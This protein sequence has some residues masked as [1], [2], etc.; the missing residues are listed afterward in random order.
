MQV[1]NPRDTDAAPLHTQRE[2]LLAHLR[3]MPPVAA[4]Q[5]SLDQADDSGVRLSAPLAPNVND[6][7]CAFGGSLVSLLTLAGWSLVT[8]RLM[9]AGVD[10]DVFVA[11]SQVQ[12]LKPVF[13]DLHAHARLQEEANFDSFITTLKTRGRAR[14]AVVAETPLA[15]G[16]IATACQSRYAAI[17]KTAPSRQRSG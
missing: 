7:G 8:W 3:S 1:G 4:L 2:A 11:E 16:G 10:A 14:I 12:Y 9:R 17:L 13:G 15:D 5:L 6:K